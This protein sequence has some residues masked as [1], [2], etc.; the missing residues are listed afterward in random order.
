[1]LKIDTKSVC[2]IETTLNQ[3]GTTLMQA[4]F[5]FVQRRFNVDTT[6]SQ[7]CLNV[8]SMSVKVTLKLIWLVESMDLQKD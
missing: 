5:N 3:H 2:N 4:L 8:A 1:M 7:R 6:L